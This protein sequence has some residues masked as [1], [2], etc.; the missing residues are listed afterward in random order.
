MAAY[1]N[2]RR[3][4]GELREAAEG[5]AAPL[6]ELVDLVPREFPQAPGGGASPGGGRRQPAGSL[7]QDLRRRGRRVT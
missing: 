3:D 5:A 7:E 1:P 4:L 6:R 2:L